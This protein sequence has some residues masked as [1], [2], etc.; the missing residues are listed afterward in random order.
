MAS[1]RKKTKRIRQ[2]KQKPN[3][4]NRKADMRRLKENL[5]ILKKLAAN[6]ES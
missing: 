5:E 6:G 2:N 3:K 4:H 1:N